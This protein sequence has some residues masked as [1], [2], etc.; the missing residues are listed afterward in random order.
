MCFTWNIIEKG[1]YVRKIVFHPYYKPYFKDI[2]P[3]NAVLY[4]HINGFFPSFVNLV[5]N[6]LYKGRRCLIREGGAV[7]CTMILVEG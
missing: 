3:R 5:W 2:H 4:T 1:V 7:T 6:V